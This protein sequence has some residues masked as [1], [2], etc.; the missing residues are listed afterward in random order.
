MSILTLRNITKRFG[1]VVAVRDVS[2]EVDQGEYVVMVG[3]SGSGK[4]TL[5]LM[6]GGFEY[7]DTGHIL[8]NDEVVDDIPPA[9][10]NTATVFQDYALFPHMRVQRNI[11]FGLKMRGATRQERR[12]RARE[13]L[14][15]VGLEGLGARR[16]H[17]LSGGQRQRVALARSLV[18]HPDIILLDEPLGA[19]DAALRLQMQRELKRIQQKVGITFVH[20]THDQEEAMHVADRI[21]VIQN[22]V[23][24]DNGPP[25]RIYY[26]PRSRFTAE[27][28]GDNN[29]V[30]GLV[31]ASGS[32]QVSIEADIGTFRVATGNTAELGL[33]PGAEALFAVRPENVRLAGRTPGNENVIAAAMV[34]EIIFAGPYIKLVTEVQGLA[35]LKV[36][37]HSA[38]APDLAVG[39][40][41]DLSFRPDDA[42]LLAQ[43]P[44]RHPEPRR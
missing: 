30:S 21:I 14:E 44:R 24:E 29:L 16:P 35:E 6:V 20:V 11:E 8:I 13:M 17:E 26:R 40:S 18:V 39:R 36:Q 43:H 19:L 38:R 37:L 12:Q 27:F 15:L 25:H 9:K 7:P 3:P 2:F 41:V 42:F 23:L 10:R 28:M 33:Q 4:T 34:K 32:N 5:L 1:D 31:T 22:G